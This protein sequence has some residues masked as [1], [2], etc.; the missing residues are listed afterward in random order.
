MKRLIFSIACL[1]LTGIIQAQS[2][3]QVND[4]GT[5]NQQPPQGR[6]SS[7]QQ[8]VAQPKKDPNASSAATNTATPSN[9]NERSRMAITD[10]G[11]PAPKAK[12]AP[13]PQQKQP[14]PAATKTVNNH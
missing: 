6:N 5:V 10:K 7:A 2:N 4:D 11:V 3:V 12:T 13:P 9:A 8:D 14:A 1:A